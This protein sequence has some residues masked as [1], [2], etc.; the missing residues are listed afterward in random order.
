MA[1]ADEFWLVSVVVQ[2][3]RQN[4]W[5]QLNNETKR[6]VLSKNW[7]FDIP[8]LKVGAM[9]KLIEVNDE[10]YH[11]DSYVEQVTRKVAAYMYEVM[12]CS[13]EEFIEAL[14][15]SNQG[16]SSYVTNFKW[17]VAKY[18]TKYSL[19]NLMEMMKKEVTDIEIELRKKSKMYN[20]IKSKIQ[21]KDKKESGTLLTRSVDDLVRKENFVLGSEYLV[22]LVVVVTI[23]MVPEWNVSYET[24]TDMVVPRSTEV[25][26]QDNEHALVTVTLFRKVVDEFR[27][28]AKENSFAVRDF[29]FKPEELQAQTIQLQS[30]AVDKMKQRGPLVRWLKTH[31]SESFV[32][33]IH[34]KTLKVFAESILRNGLPV[35]SSL[36]VLMLPEKKAVR[37]LHELLEKLYGDD[38]NS[39]N[40]IDVPDIPDLGAAEYFSYVFLKINLNF[41]NVN[42]MT[43]F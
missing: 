3:S 24:L 9:G 36:P 35:T 37:K 21:D 40:M 12:E 29:E 32:A 17:D 27:H 5:D 30:L 18:P 42:N 23:A 33:W 38:L 11:V 22:T 31:F 34:L 19:K 7:K 14:R 4:T 15:A 43:V 20:T 13:K 39:L 41:Y 25:V 16:L 2:N 10:L 26:Y 28:K 8:D 1:D 6:K